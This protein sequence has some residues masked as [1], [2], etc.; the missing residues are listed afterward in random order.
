MKEATDILEDLK[1]MLNEKS[2][3]IDD[4]MKRKFSL[5]AEQKSLIDE[6]ILCHTADIYSLKGEQSL[7]YAVT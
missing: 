5:S 2:K 4:L 1:D 6:E 7:P 3:D